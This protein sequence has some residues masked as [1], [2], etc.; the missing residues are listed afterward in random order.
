MD[1]PFVVRLTRFER[2]TPSFG[3]KCSIQLS[4][5]RDNVRILPAPTPPVNH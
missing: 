3:G 5:R 1:G 4:Y 2:M